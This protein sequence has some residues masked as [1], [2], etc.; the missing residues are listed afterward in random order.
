MRM[1]E[2]GIRSPGGR[3][4][5]NV[6]GAFVL[7]SLGAC[8]DQPLGSEAEKPDR[9]RLG[10]PDSQWP[11][12]GGGPYNQNYS[13]LTQIDK[14]NVANLEVAWVYNYGAGEHDLGDLGLDYRFEVTPLL[15][16]G[17]MY[18]STPTSPNAPGLKSTITALVPETGEVLWRYESP[19]NI[20]GRGIAYWPGDDET[21]PRI[22]FGT[23]GGFLMAVD[24]TT[25][26]LARDFG[27]DGRIDVYIGVTNEVVGDTRRKTYTIPNPVTI[28]KD[29]VITGARP[30][31]AGPPGPRGDIRA[32]S[33]RTGRL[34]WTFHVLPRP[35]EP[36]DS[37][38]E[39]VDVPDLTGANVWSTMTLDPENGILY[40]TTGDINARG[41][42]VSGPEPYANSLLAID[43]DTGNL[44]WYRKIVFKDQW[45]WDSPTP[46]VLFDL[47]RDG[48]SIPAVLY[49]GKQGLVFIFDRL[50]G[51]PLNGYEMR[52][53]PGAGER[54]VPKGYWPEQP[55]PTAPGPIARTGMTRD[56]IPDLVP[57]MKEHCERI[58]DQYQP[59]SPGLY[60]LPPT[61]RAIIRAP[62]STGGP[63][64]GGGS[65]HPRLGYFFINVQEPVRIDGPRI[66][67]AARAGRNDFSFTLE[68][69][70]TLSCGA[71]P[72]GA[73]VAVDV[74]NLR[75]AWKVPLG[76]NEKL[77]EA[78]RRT[79]AR[80]IGGNITTA[81]GLVFIAATNDR[82]FR[83]FDAENGELLWEHRLPAGGHST[84]VTYMG[85]DGK[86]YVVIAAGGGTSVGRA[87]APRMSDSLVAFRLP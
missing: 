7:M 68:D 18:I 36:N 20:H 40:A 85:A 46:P 71:L 13:P 49:T 83:A 27:L 77:G 10:I 69:G 51:E 32:F 50:T 37:G 55:W 60:A 47:E 70:T 44:R 56:E 2:R 3:V 6:L 78:G 21:P 54:P 33:A 74:R 26:E 57:G 66:D 63:N 59:L 61:D 24:A 41:L 67:G 12:Y 62:G 82:Y 25:G 43:A 23:D 8:G 80:N 48:R 16:G 86:Q 64:W 79:G 31:E 65:Y 19:Y 34:K 72:W 5:A 58:W 9:V 4:V 39:P 53:A 87:E 17:V 35:G 14:S 81:S 42:D 73:L 29:L 75:I 11:T 30:G 45:D 1:L 52:P 22:F 84:P 15:I 76:I 28:Y 38:L